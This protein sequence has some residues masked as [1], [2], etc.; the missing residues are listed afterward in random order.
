MNDA[1]DWLETKL[2]SIWNSIER[3]QIWKGLFGETHPEIL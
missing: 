2:K 1:E 3:N